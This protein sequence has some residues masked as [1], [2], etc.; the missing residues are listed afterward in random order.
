[1]EG[2]SQASFRPVRSNRDCYLCVLSNKWVRMRPVPAIACGTWIPVG[3]GNCEGGQI[4]PRAS[5]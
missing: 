4:V 2:N 5:Q 3:M 1:M